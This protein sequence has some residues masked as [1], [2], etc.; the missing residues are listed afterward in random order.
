MFIV[1]KIPN[2]ADRV[3]KDKSHLLCTDVN[4]SPKTG[5][6]TKIKPIFDFDEYTGMLKYIPVLSVLLLL[7]MLLLLLL[8]SLV[9]LMLLGL[10]SLWW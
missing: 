6:K 3:K 2:N 5:M 10:G 8:V 1:R 7:M 4:Q 9:L